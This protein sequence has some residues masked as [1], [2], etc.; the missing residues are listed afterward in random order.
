[1][2]KASSSPR[3]TS[4]ITIILPTAGSHTMQVRT[5]VRI[6][7]VAAAALQEIDR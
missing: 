4:Y 5:D 6:F 2:K 7:R 3:H 1:M